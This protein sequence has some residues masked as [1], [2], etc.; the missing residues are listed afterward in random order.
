[1]TKQ[2]K[3]SDERV[4]KIWACKQGIETL[5]NDV[6]QLLSVAKD[7]IDNLDDKI[8]QINKELQEGFEAYTKTQDTMNNSESE[9]KETL[10]EL[11]ETNVRDISSK[12]SDSELDDT[13]KEVMLSLREYEAIHTF[14]HKKRSEIK[15]IYREEKLSLGDKIIKL[16]DLVETHCN[17][18]SKFAKKAKFR[19][20]TIKD[21]LKQIKGN[22][23]SKIKKAA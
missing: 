9:I 23:L 13:L 1:M 8:T 2:K 3:Q 16:E 7:P 22:Y 10:S 5:L 15:E 14:L 4:E 19:K 20:K 17:N 11:K 18:M 21:Y 6:N 12:I